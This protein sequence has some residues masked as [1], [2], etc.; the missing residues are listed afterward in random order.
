MDI[1]EQNENKNRKE[2]CYMNAK[3]I[4][5]IIAVYESELYEE[6]DRLEDQEIFPTMELKELRGKLIALQVLKYRIE[7]AESEACSE[8]KSLG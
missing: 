5:E 7:K 6:R 2:R 1:M 8:T 3:E 4:M